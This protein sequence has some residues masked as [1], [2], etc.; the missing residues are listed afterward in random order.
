MSDI[1]V[2]TIADNEE[3]LRQVSLPVD[4]NDKDLKK[5]ILF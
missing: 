3:Y 5:D 2:V 4:F 1:K